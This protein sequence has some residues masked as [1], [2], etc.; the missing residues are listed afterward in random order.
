M[1]EVSH[2]VKQLLN[3]VTIKVCVEQWAPQSAISGPSLELLAADGDYAKMNSHFA[4]V[5]R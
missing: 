5:E 3:K 4:L 1:S 2:W